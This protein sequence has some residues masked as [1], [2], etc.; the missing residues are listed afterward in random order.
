MIQWVGTILFN[1][2]S[3]TTAGIFPSG[4]DPTVKAIFYGLTVGPDIAASCTFI[5]AGYLQV[6][7]S[8]H[9]F[10]PDIELDN[11]GW[12]SG[13]NNALGGVG[14]LINA[15]GFMFAQQGYLPAIPLLIGSV[16]F[17]IGSFLLWYEQCKTD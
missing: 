7:E 5:I 8:T 15:V 9:Q 12:Y 16:F 3:V 6:C 14:F 2:N 17:F 1:I 4:S 10:L 13:Y 11:L